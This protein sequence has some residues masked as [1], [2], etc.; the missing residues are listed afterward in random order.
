[1]KFDKLDVISNKMTVNSC[2]SKVI[3]ISNFINNSV[4]YELDNNKWNCASKA[5][6]INNIELVKNDMLIFSALLQDVSSSLDEMNVIQQKEN[7]IKRLL[8]ENKIL[9]L[10]NSAE[11]IT[12][13]QENE[14][15]INDCQQTI[16]NI[17]M[18]LLEQW[19]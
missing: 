11:N 18:K 4:I 14:I 12:K 5:N 10:N 8:E 16:K 9:K 3:E 6:V 7:E 2:A 1:M 19:R 13:I 15:M 17:Q